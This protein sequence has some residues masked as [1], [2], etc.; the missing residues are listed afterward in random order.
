MGGEAL[1]VERFRPQ[2]TQLITRLKGDLSVSDRV[3]A[4][5]VAHY[6]APSR[7]YH[8]FSHITG[9]LDLL[10]QLDIELENRNAV[11]LAVWFHDVIYEVGT[12]LDNEQASADFSAEQL[13]LLNLDLTLIKTVSNLILDTK[14]SQRPATWDGCVLVDLDLAQLGGSA[15]QFQRDTDNIRREYAI[16]PYDR[17]WSGRGRILQRF[18]NRPRIYYTEPFYTRFEAAARRNLSNSIASIR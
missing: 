11:Q 8:D 17:F 1:F 5:L 18:L 14:H 12:G 10:E 13:T 6:T 7:H 3:Y 16:V 4:R 9:M 15:E 2:W